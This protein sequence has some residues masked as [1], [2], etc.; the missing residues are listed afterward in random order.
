MADT[1]SRARWVVEQLN[2]TVEMELAASSYTEDAAIELAKKTLRH[3]V[4]VIRKVVQE[5]D[6]YFTVP[7]KPVG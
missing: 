6:R 7:R 3:G 5:Q 2:G 1:E 4:Y